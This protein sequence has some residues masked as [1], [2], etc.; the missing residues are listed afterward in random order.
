MSPLPTLPVEVLRS[1]LTGARVLNLR[2][3][4]SVQ[5]TRQQCEELC[6]LLCEEEQAPTPV[7]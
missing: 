7:G 5:L 3:L 4:L 2:G 1:R 6:R